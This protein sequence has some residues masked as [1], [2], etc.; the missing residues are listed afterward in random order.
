MRGKLL[1]EFVEFIEF[2][3]VIGDSDYSFCEV[4]ALSDELVELVGG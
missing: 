3:R 1:A 2:S 4:E